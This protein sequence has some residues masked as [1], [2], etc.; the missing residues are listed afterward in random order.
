M[1][2]KLVTVVGATGTQ[3]ASVIDALIVDPAYT[4]RALTRNTT[5]EAAK[6]LIAK[7]V[8]VVQ[9][10]ANDVDSL[11]SAFH[12]SYAVYAVTDF[13]EPFGRGGPVE[14]TRVET[15]QGIN[16]AKAAAA[17]PTLEH[18]IW[19][20]LPDAK[21]ISDGKFLVPHFEA[22]NQVDRY[23]KN[24][25]ELWKKTTL[26]W[27]T[28][29]A[30]NYSF[31]MYTPIFVPSAG[32]Y[33]QLSSTPGSVPILSV[34]DARVNIGKFVAAALAQPEKTKTKT[35]LA[36]VEETTSDAHLQ[37]WAKAQE[38]QAQLVQIGREAFNDVWPLWAEELGVMMEFWE[39]A[40]E[41]SWTGEEIVRK[42]DLGVSGL[43]GMKEAFGYLKF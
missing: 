40:G 32:K 28:F 4:L 5:S 41:R 20:T 10:D 43:V 3:G 17:T 26:L 37:V 7:G 39:W 30:Q 24:E 31:P 33:I 27:V 22:K 13:F 29:Y 9:A 42:E 6:A 18:Y 35:V 16:L 36:Y 12:G 1:S 25:P 23:I 11:T 2:P 38:K 21:T 34:G 19:S 8:E 14:G 15:Q